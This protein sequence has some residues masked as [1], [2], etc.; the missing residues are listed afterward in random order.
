[1]K[2]AKL[3]VAILTILASPL[4]LA[5]TPITLDEVV[6][7]ANNTEQTIHSVTANMTIITAEEIQDRQHTTLGDAL[8]TIPGIFIRTNGGLGTSSSISMRGSS[9]QNVLV[10]KDGII[11][12]EPMGLSGANFNHIFLTD[13][14]RIEIIKGPQSG[15]WGSDASAGV[16]NIITKKSKKTA[17]ASLEVGSN[18]YKKLATSIG[19]GNDKVSFVVNFLEISTDGFSA[20]KLYRGSVNAHEND[21][22]NQTDIS[23]KMNIVPVKGHRVQTFVKKSSASTNF[24]DTNNPNANNTGS[25]DSIL[26]SISYNYS[27]NSLQARVFLNK[28]EINRISIS[29]WGSSPFS[30]SIKEYGVSGQY[31]YLI[32]HFFSIA[33][34]EKKLQDEGSNN[35]Y[36]NTGL[37]ASNTNQFLNKNLIFTQSIRLDKFDR[38][39]DKITGKIGAKGYFTDNIFLSANYSTGYRAPTLDESEHSTLKPESTK[40]FDATFGAYGFELTYF[41]IKTKDKIKY[42]SGWPIT[43]YKN[44][45]GTSTAKGVA[46]SY[47]HFIS[48]INSDISV[49][50]TIQKIRD[51]NNNKLSRQ[52][53]QMAQLT[54][55]NYSLNNTRL[56]ISTQY[57]GQTYDIS[58]GAKNKSQIGGYFVVDLT[59]DYSINQN[60]TIFGRVENL[61]NQDYTNAVAGYQGISNTPSH[62]YNK[63][64]TQL[65]IGVRGQL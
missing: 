63:G 4:L 56:G 37:S 61:F 45:A 19:A 27:K 50:Y 51:H 36:T 23:F 14:A 1:M 52:P 25:F 22:F 54:F 8:Q 3:S 49:N 38:F 30:S 58:W 20:V 35:N 9:G 46:A 59:A 42:I 21:G 17:V 48:T 26:R 57:I 32:D 40:G 39:A 53:E 16:I 18:N 43:V 5:E 33:A 47:Q 10:L 60:L 62:I 34:S 64:G 55:D 65:F 12:N 13:V 11:L 7:T 6:V 41:E 24:D 28:T 15:T 44:L 31:T 2:L 29:A